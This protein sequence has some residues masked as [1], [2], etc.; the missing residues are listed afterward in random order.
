MAVFDYPATLTGASVD[1][2]MSTT[3]KNATDPN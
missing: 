1:E 2:R 3:T